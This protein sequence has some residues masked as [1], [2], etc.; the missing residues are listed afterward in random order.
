M[1]NI[2]NI[3]LNNIINLNLRHHCNCLCDYVVFFKKK[4]RNMK[5]CDYVSLGF[6]NNKNKIESTILNSAIVNN[7]VTKTNDKTS[8][9]KRMSNN[10]LFKVEKKK[11][12]ISKDNLD[13]EKKKN[14]IIQ[15]KNQEL[16]HNFLLLFKKNIPKNE[17][18]NNNKNIIDSNIIINNYSF[19][20]KPIEIDEEKSIQLIDNNN[21]SKEKIVNSIKNNDIWFQ[22][23]GMEDDDINDDI[24][25]DDNDDHNSQTWNEIYKPTILNDFVGNKVTVSFLDQWLNGVKGNQ[26]I[27]GKKSS[28]GIIL[29]GPPGVGKTL[30]VQLLCKKHNYNLIE[31]NSNTLPTLD[32]NSNN[33]N[34]SSIFLS[35]FR[36][37]LSDQDKPNAILFHGTDWLDHY[38]NAYQELVH[39]LKPN[40]N[41]SKKKNQ[42]EKKIKD[43]I[44]KKIKTDKEPQWNFP[45]FIT[46][47]NIS[48]KLDILKN[49]YSKKKSLSYI[50]CQ[51]VYLY[52]ISEIE[53]KAFLKIITFKEKRKN[54]Q[55]DSFVTDMLTNELIDNIVH[56][57]SGDLRKA[58]ITLEFL[59]K[60]KPLHFDDI[61][62]N[63]L[64]IEEN[65]L[66]QQGREDYFQNPYLHAKYLLEHSFYS[67]IEKA[68][69][70]EYCSNDYTIFSFIWN[71]TIQN[72]ELFL[73][74][75]KTSM[76]YLGE[77]YYDHDYFKSKV[78]V[79]EVLSSITESWSDS[80]YFENASIHHMNEYDPIIQSIQ[81]SNKIIKPNLILH[82]KK[83]TKLHI[84]SSKNQLLLPSYDND[85]YKI[86]DT[87]IPNFQWLKNWKTFSIDES[88][89]NREFQSRFNIRKDDIC[90]VASIFNT[91][92]QLGWKE[93]N[94]IF[95][96]KFIKKNHTFMVKNVYTYWYCYEYISEC[97]DSMETNYLKSISYS[98]DKSITLK[99]LWDKTLLEYKQFYNIINQHI[100]NLVKGNFIENSNDENGFS[101][102]ME[103]ERF[104]QWNSKHW[105]HPIF[106]WIET[107]LILD[108]DRETILLHQN[109]NNTDDSFSLITIDHTLILEV[110]DFDHIKF[111]NYDDTP[112]NILLWWN[113]HRKFQQIHYKNNVKNFPVKD[114]WKKTRKYFIDF[115][116]A[117]D[118][119]SSDF[120]ILK[121]C[122]ILSNELFVDLLEELENEIKKIKLF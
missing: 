48:K 57:C 102:V 109:N 7:E 12:K 23:I 37:K 70:I 66:I 53:M 90:F 51:V 36:K 80:D 2:L 101:I 4:K 16:N 69:D 89:L 76:N 98:F 31:L 25:V 49:P 85:Y 120:K 84:N 62:S 61:I 9:I 111:S 67:N 27:K 83:P 54:N 33:C 92:A 112:Y 34:I 58:I 119:I 108:I 45:V 114:Q 6:K 87:L 96:E 11:Q 106:F 28:L 14:L 35:I 117:C 121:Q 75:Q 63:D 13:E 103:K 50:P 104:L 18:K 99:F 5:K 26:Y 105:N 91:I 56:Y 38:A 40:Y 78:S 77:K 65:N 15:K 74:S 46:V 86:R 44:V 20:F 3:I 88:C 30:L 118:F 72:I 41:I 59:M 94:S 93:K 22:K 39:Y 32:K 110:C 64:K 10:F 17:E 81:Y 1:N 115:L 60:T 122:F 55:N 47:N 68:F 71:S 24:N 29:C 116:F 19:F 113:M 95:L 21:N 79:L 73:K 107:I 100:V 82:P 97:D 8:S 42:S 43:T 52:P